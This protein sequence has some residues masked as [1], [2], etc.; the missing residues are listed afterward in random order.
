MSQVK[1][2]IKDKPRE[3]VITYQVELKYDSDGDIAIYINDISVAYF[4]TSEMEFGY[5]KHDLED[6]GLSIWPSQDTI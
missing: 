4:S 2:E 6:F 3:K 5:F 1:F